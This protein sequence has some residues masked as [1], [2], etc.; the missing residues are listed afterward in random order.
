MNIKE[1]LEQ[2][3]QMTFQK[4]ALSAKLSLQLFETVVGVRKDLATIFQK[5]PYA[6][7]L[8]GL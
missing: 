3:N 2:P 1:S 4:N 7:C 8:M 5:L 6:A